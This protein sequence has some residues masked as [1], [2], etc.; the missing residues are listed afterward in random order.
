MRLEGIKKMLCTSVIF[1]IF[2]GALFADDG[3]S[4]FSIFAGKKIDMQIIYDNMSELVPIVGYMRPEYTTDIDLEF[5]TAVDS[6]IK[7]QMIMTSTFKPVSMVKWLTSK[8]GQNKASSIFD[9]IK[10]LN[11]ERYPVN[12]MGIYKP[13]IYKVG[14]EIVIKI[15]VFPFSKGGYPISAVR[16]VKSEKEMKEAI[17]YLLSD[18]SK[19]LK[20]QNEQFAK[21]AVEPFKINCRTLIEQRTGEF[22]FITT[23]FS[24]QEGVEI[25]S[26]DDYF[27]ELF[28]YQAQCTG[29]F[30]ATT[31]KNIDEYISKDTLWNTAYSGYA[32]Y[33]V[34]GDITLSNRFN[35]LTLQLI[36]ARTGQLVR[37][38]K[39]ITKSF[40]LEDIWN[41]N[42]MFISD[43]CK[44]LFNQQDVKF[45]ENIDNEGKYFYMNGMFAGFDSIEN[46]PIRAGKT[47]INTGTKFASDVS[48]NPNLVNEK[49]NKD[50]YIYTNNDKVFI[51]KGREGAYVWNLLE[52]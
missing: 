9:F 47:I 12:V 43:F 26:T 25:K 24:N 20:V 22:D 39:H 4:F 38:T 10:E 33:V 15:S 42:Y 13:Y 36:N 8:Y 44:V 23:S 29:L 5:A 49:N 21:L 28:S 45:I 16:I 52:K 30:A 34:R 32:D 27:S 50:Y 37:S 41:Y 48:I 31:T 6:E 17:P 18:L 2:T 40:T 1:V 46:V 7:N 3:N 11:E 51:Y 19:L 35:I 14:N